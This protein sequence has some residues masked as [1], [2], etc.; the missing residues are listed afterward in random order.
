MNRQWG[1]SHL[2]KITIETIALKQIKTCMAKHKKKEAE[3]LQ[4][5]CITVW[6]EV[7]ED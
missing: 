4:N 3:N 2:H 6:M 7:S 1:I 5:L